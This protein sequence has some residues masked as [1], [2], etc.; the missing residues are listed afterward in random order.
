[1]ESI[2]EKQTDKLVQKSIELVKLIKFP[3]TTINYSNNF[4]KL[5]KQRDVN[6]ENNIG[7]IHLIKQNKDVEYES[8][9]EKKVL[10]LLSYCPYILDIKVQSLIIEYKVND[11]KHLY[12]P[13]FQILFD[14]GRMAIIEVK[15]YF[16]MGDYIV[17]NKYNV[18]KDFC[19]RKGIGYMMIDDMMNDFETIKD[20][21]YNEED[22]K[23]LMNYLINHS[24]M[25]YIDFLKYKN[26][27]NFNSAEFLSMII[28]DDDIIFHRSPFYI[29][30]KKSKQ[31][32]EI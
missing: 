21:K 32:N 22:K 16:S 4:L 8:F 11:K 17:K 12:Y 6:P 29:K 18:L 9:S 24:Q 2:N 20:T 5:Q 19:E 15:D 30:Y 3:N 14:D 31:I 23:L 7:T 28:N 26:E 27:I 25:K 1:M 13:D 10:E